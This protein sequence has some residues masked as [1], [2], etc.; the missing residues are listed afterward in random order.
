MIDEYLEKVTQIKNS[1]D[2]KKRSIMSDKQFSNGGKADLIRIA[3]R[4]AN[5]KISS[6]KAEYEKRKSDRIT[7]IRSFLY[8]LGHKSYSTESDKQMKMMS[9]RDAVSRVETM[10]QGMSSGLGGGKAKETLFKAARNAEQMGDSVML[11]AIGFVAKQNGLNDVAGAVAR[12][13]GDGEIFDELMALESKQDGLSKERLAF[14]L[15]SE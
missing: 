1:L 4:E 12:E 10:I 11:Q 5:E 6:L 8:T 7:E 2:Q 9:Y 14:N 13:S 3:V 15:A